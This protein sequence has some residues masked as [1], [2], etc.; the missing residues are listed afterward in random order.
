[1]SFV[2]ALKVS[3]LHPLR[4]SFPRRGTRDVSAG[5]I[6]SRKCSS[7]SPVVALYAGGQASPSGKLAAK[8]TD[9]AEMESGGQ[10]PPDGQ[11]PPGGAGA[12]GG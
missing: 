12:G 11:A 5:K 2:I 1:M 6:H 10:R 4:G 8:Q 3:P 7:S 9:R